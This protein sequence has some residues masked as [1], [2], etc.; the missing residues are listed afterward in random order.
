MG[1]PDRRTP[2][3]AAL[4]LAVS[5]GLVGCSDTDGA[6]A[7]GTVVADAP[8]IASYVALGDSFTAAPLVPDTSLADG[9]FRSSG[10]YPSL[11]ADELDARLRD[12]SCSGASTADLAGRQQLG[13]GT[14]EGTAAPQLD[15]L[16]R[17]TD[18]VTLGIGG[19]DE[20]LFQTLVQQCTAL[21][22]QPGSPCTDA[23]ASTV[24]DPN[25]VFATVD[26]R[27]T[28]ALRA[29]QRR[30]P[31]A[32]VVLVGYP[33]LVDAAGDCPAMPLADGDVPLVVELERRLNRTLARAARRTA[34]EYVDMRP[35][36]RGHEICSAD[37]W[38]NG[39]VTDQQR[40]AAYHPFAEGQ[41]A[42]ADELLALLATL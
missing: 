14:S 34:A 1:R 4:V 41:H 27:V 26:R 12:V 23:L 16:R 35:V 24:V 21:A 30:S 9:C 31:E 20:Q 7:E 36:S 18:L 37:P 33:R 15:A 19:N 32:V 42:V 6:S 29:I 25:E 13:F 10:N 3:L 11:V 22:D 17:G 2:A 39:R 28:R 40:A 5:G 38:V 8:T